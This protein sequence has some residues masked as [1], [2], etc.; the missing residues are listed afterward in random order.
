MYQD[1]INIG[2]FDDLLDHAKTIEPL[3]PRERNSLGWMSRLGSRLKLVDDF[4]AIIALY[5]GADAT[6]TALV[7]GS[8][9]L[10]LTLASSIGHS[11]R[12]VL[13]ML[14][15]LSLALPRFKSYENTPMSKELEN[16]LVDVYTEV[17]SFSAR[18]IYS[19]A[20]P[21]L[22]LLYDAPESLHKDFRRT[23]QRVKRLSSSVEREADLA[24]MKTEELRYKEILDAM[25]DLKESRIQESEARRC[26][27]I[28]SGLSLRFWGRDQ[29]LQAIRDTLDPAQN[30]TS[31]RAFTLYGMGGVGKTQIA[32]QYANQSR[33]LYR[34]ILW[35]AADNMGQSFREIA[36]VLGLVE[37]EEETQDSAVA[38]LK[39]KRWLED[40]RELH[41]YSSKCHFFN[42]AYHLRSARIVRSLAKVFRFPLA[43]HLRQHR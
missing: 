16:T 23:L 38:I 17:I 8:V 26:H 7:W 25:V 5:F 2:S 42:I 3:S 36:K 1:I 28:P 39:V 9:R 37:S 15:E 34:T 18:A 11:P 13:Y 32:L 43:C 21:P 14:E 10:M 33:E 40:A 20:R 19:R 27:F 24:R 12:D 4:L 30:R 31:L 35:V 41:L 22:F 6:F 29:I